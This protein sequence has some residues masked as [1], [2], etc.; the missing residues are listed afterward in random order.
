M[1]EKIIDNWNKLVNKNDIVYH[2]GDFFLG[3]KSDLVN[4]VSKL[5]VKIYLL[6]GNHDRLTPKTYEE[7]GIKILKNAPISID[8]YKVILSHRSLPDTMIKNN[9]LN[10]H[11]HIHERKLEDI[12]DNSLYTKT[13]HLNVY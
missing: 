2:L 8:E 7:C 6:K 1:N 13:K 9:Y 11:G 3:P 5:N 12:Y 10:I 4:I